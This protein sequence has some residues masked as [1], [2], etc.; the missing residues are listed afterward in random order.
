MTVLAFMGGS[1]VD[2]PAM[3]A[4]GAFIDT[5]RPAPSGAALSPLSPAQLRGQ[6]LFQDETVGC[7]TCHNG[8]HLTDNLSWD[9]DSQAT[10]FDIREFQTP[11]LHGL[12]RS[13]PY[14]HDGSA[15]TLRDLVF[16]F[17]ATDRMGN[18]SHLDDSAL[19]DLAAFLAT[20]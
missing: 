8:A 15:A 17:V 20:L 12:D 16:N 4:I 6:A 13:G 14:M 1:G 19:E 9:V 7:A 2:A 5:I 11:V 18:G 3:N 10:S